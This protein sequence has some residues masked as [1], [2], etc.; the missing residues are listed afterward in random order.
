MYCVTCGQVQCASAADMLDIGLRKTKPVVIV[1][2]VV[3]VSVHTLIYQMLAETLVWPL[4][5]IQCLVSILGDHV[6]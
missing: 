2:W 3:V 1:I 5:T 4:K 6:T